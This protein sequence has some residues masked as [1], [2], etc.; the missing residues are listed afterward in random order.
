MI[1]WISDQIQN[2]EFFAG[3]IGA[4]M[5]GWV[6]WALRNIPRQVYV[7]VKAKFGTSVSIYS[8][9]LRFHRALKFFEEKGFFDSRKR[10]Y[11]HGT[12]EQNLRADQGIY[13]C[14][15]KKRPCICRMSIEKD[16]H[17]NRESLLSFYGF[18]FGKKLRKE[19][20]AEMKAFLRDEKKRRM[21]VN[22]VDN[23]Q[24]RDFRSRS[25]DSIFVSN[26][27]RDEIKYALEDFKD[28][29]YVRKELGLYRKKSFL[30]HGSPGTGKTS[31]AYAIATYLNFDIYF[32]NINGF[33]RDSHF[34][35]MWSAI[36][37]NSVVVFDDIDAQNLDLKKRDE[38]ENKVSLA[39][40]LS[41]LDGSMSRS[42]QVIII[43]TNNIDSLD[44]A[45]IRS[46]RIDH[47]IEIP[48][49]D[50][51]TALDL[52]EF[53]TGGRDE[54]ILSGLNPLLGSEIQQRC[55]ERKAL[56][57]EKR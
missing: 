33:L 3:M 37:K 2:N 13:V 53:I 25:F 50:K 52:V 6:G 48:P 19:F 15:Y 32:M 14:F 7:W 18:A 51:E 5:I 38:K 16:E 10:Y 57:S 22:T 23:W 36:P 29:D 12:D 1:N 46:G 30:F 39:C 45:L 9:N 44:K 24:Y 4:G 55:F 35:Q 40:L 26:K 47:K 41:C 27:V 56:I 11:F 34:L 49:M 54:S 20:L 21:Y 42:D 28:W 43:N 17:G 8:R 31:L